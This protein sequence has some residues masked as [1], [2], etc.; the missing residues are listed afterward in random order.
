MEGIKDD[1]FSQISSDPRFRS[2]PKSVRKVK[3]DKRFQSLFTDRR[4]QV[5]Y[6]VDKRG[7]PVDQSSHENFRKYYD[8]SSDES[9]EEEEEE[10]NE[11]ENQ[12]NNETSSKL[13]KNPSKSP[14]SNNWTV[15]LSSEK[16]ANS[17]DD[18]ET[19]KNGNEINKNNTNILK[20]S[21]KSH[22]DLNDT[23]RT[24]KARMT[25]EIKM[26]LRDP[27]IDYARGVGALLSESSSEEESNS[28]SESDDETQD[29]GWG[30]LDKDAETTDEPTDRLAVLHMDWDRIRAVDLMVLFNSFLPPN[31]IINSIT[32]Y[33]SEFGLER[34][35]E[36]EG[37]GPIELVNIKNEDEETLDEE[38]KEGKRYHMERLRQ[39]QL[40]RLK[41]YYAIVKFDSAETSN[42]V[43][44]ECD[45]LE[46]ESSATKL[47]LR[48][49]PEEETFDQE[50]HEV[51][52]AM[53]DPAK[54]EPRLFINTALQQG[55]VELTWDEMDP[56]R[57]EITKKIQKNADNVDNDDIN[58]YLACSSGEEEDDENHQ[59]DT[60]IVLEIK[61]DSEGV[62]G[63]DKIAQYKSL[64][65]TL[66]E[67]EDKKRNRD[68]DLEITWDVGMKEKAEKSI[69]EKLNTPQTPFEEMLEKRKQKKKLR[70]EEKLKQKGKEQEIGSEDN[71]CSD[72]EIPSDVDMADPFFRSEHQV[73]TVKK[74]KKA[75][76]EEES[77]EAKQKKAELELLL[78]EENDSE[79][80]KSH[81]NM[82]SIQ[83]QENDGKK[84]K[85][86]KQL[87]KKN[88]KENI[89][90]NDDFQVDI[91]DDRFSALFTSHHF[92]IDPAEP[93]F[94]K[95]KAMDVIISEKLKRRKQEHEQDLTPPTLLKT[96]PELSLL[97]K[98]IKN[99]TKN[100]K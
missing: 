86:R 54:Y 28:E 97:V 25:D 35:K 37:K 87:K 51:C 44:T 33:P 68:V 55:K 58:A 88:I 32:I 45:G 42:H 38:S 92:N 96:D 4:F 61:K 95:T 71:L 34:M 62:K 36:E 47:D 100:K 76:N 60:S 21:K 43:Y 57:Q 83:D 30:E 89:T 1:R 66:E 75:N 39:Y 50:P 79:V 98:S 73:S 94:R 67:E 63:N 48:F 29:H 74:N 99:K 8:L 9:G 12:Q 23:D 82:K 41:Y 27:N 72:D 52:I 59:D 26:K 64:L 24:E 15:T 10:E 2:V 85:R 6:S 17:L 78:M 80:Q 7:R 18:N 31:G 14:K 65:A 5:K 16:D 91:T 81:F 69:K 56:R 19:N 53:P 22:I 93:Q 84:K 13:I 49:V 77:E 3:I 70:K 20:K 90:N 11:S 40:N 46:Y